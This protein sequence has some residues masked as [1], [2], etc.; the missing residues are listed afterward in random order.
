MSVPIY[1]LAALTGAGCYTNA[2]LSGG[3]HMIWGPPYDDATY[4]RAVQTYMNRPVHGTDILNR[5][6]AEKANA[7]KR[8][9][10]DRTPISGR[11]TSQDWLNLYARYVADFPYKPAKMR[12]IAGVGAPP[13]PPPGAPPA[14]GPPP[15]GHPPGRHPPAGGPPP[16]DNNDDNNDDDAGNND[17]DDD[18]GDLLPMVP[19]GDDGNVGDDDDE[20]HLPFPRSLRM[21]DEDFAR[22]NRVHGAITARYVWD[23]L[24]QMTKEDFLRMERDEAVTIYVILR[25]W[26]FSTFIPP[27]ELQSENSW[28]RIKRFL[29]SENPPSRPN[30]L[31]N[32]Y[33]TAPP[34]TSFSRLAMLMTETTHRHILA[35]IELDDGNGNAPLPRPAQ[36]AAAPSAPASAAA[37]P[38]SIPTGFYLNKKTGAIER[39]PRGHA[40]NSRGIL[41]KQRSVLTQR[42]KQ[43]K[44]A[45]NRANSKK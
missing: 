28:E 26:G 11:D 14:G 23:K 12:E 31:I 29:R 25:M 21:L 18:D 45:A 32:D 35:P 1:N 39:I 4:R 42:A 15:G 2:A 24:K 30:A 44:A 5:T 27:S 3:A 10:K 33:R 34:E 8:H 6:V 19:G 9:L 13:P 41:Y 36:A 7:L 38:P 40:V 20:H 16:D 17:D 37:A 22:E 43:R